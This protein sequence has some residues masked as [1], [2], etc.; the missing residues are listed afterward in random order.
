MTNNKSSQ[1]KVIQ[2]GHSQMTFLVYWKFVWRKYQS[3]RT[4]VQNT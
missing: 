4:L 3:I 1:L 2:K